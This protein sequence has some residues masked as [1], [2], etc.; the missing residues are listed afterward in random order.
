VWG[1]S[2]HPSDSACRLGNC[3][4][5]MRSA[6]SS[7]E[8]Q[9]LTMYAVQYELLIERT[10]SHSSA[11][12][13]VKHHRQ[14][15]RQDLCRTQPLVRARRISWQQ[16]RVTRWLTND[17]G[18]SQLVLDADQQLQR[19][20]H[21]S[22]LILRV[23]HAAGRNGTKCYGARGQAAASRIRLCDQPTTMHCRVRDGR[24]TILKPN[25]TR[26]MH[27]WSGV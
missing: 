3:K 21:T 24:L 20:R 17:E 22:P 23:D 10:R 9:W 18:G 11:I 6:P 2:S 26:R 13:S 15:Q 19:S 4:R 7:L 1:R 8:L 5:Q 16:Q 25:R 12:P 14:F 27:G